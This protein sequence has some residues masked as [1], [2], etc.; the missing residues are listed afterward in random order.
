MWLIQVNSFELEQNSPN[1]VL[2]FD[3][4]FESSSVK[5]LSQRI[6]LVTNKNAQFSQFYSTHN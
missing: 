2:S 5:I 1:R 4:E 3:F 6:E